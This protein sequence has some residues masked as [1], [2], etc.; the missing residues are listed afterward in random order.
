MSRDGIWY[1]QNLSYILKW[2]LMS[3]VCDLE[4]TIDKKGAAAVAATQV[5]S[6]C[7]KIIKDKL[8]M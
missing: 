2:N 7:V 3:A 6:M 5:L 1:E 4:K 8:C